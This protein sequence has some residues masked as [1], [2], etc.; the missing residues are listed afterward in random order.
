MSFVSTEFLILAV[1]VLIAYLALPHRL[2]NLMLLCASY[3]FYGWWDWRFLGLL[4]LA[5]G[6]AY[7]SAL[8]IDGTEN[9]R[10]RKAFVALGVTANLGILCVFKY[11]DFFIVSLMDGLAAIGTPAQLPLL[12]LVLPIG[13]SFFTFQTISY[14]VDVY[15]KSIGADRN[16]VDV[17]LYV[18]FFPQLIAGPIERGAHF[19]PQ[20]RLPRT[21]GADNVASG[22]YLALWGFFKKIVIADNLA[23]LVGE[24][25]SR[26]DPSGLAVVLACYAFA[27]QIYCDFSG[28]TDIA[29]GIARTMGFDLLVNFRLPYFATNPSDFWQR[30]HISLSSWLRDYLYI[31]LGG[32]RGGAARTYRNLALTM[33]LGGLWHGAAWNFALWGAYQGALLVTFGLFRSRNVARAVTR[34]TRRGFIFWL[35]VFGFFQLTC[36]GWLLFRAEDASQ[37][38]RLIR[39]ILFNPIGDDVS[40]DFIVK[41]FALVVPLICFQIF[42]YYRRDMEPWRGWR[43]APNVAFC[44]GVFY[45]IIFLGNH[46]Q[47]LF[48]YFQF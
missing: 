2:Q 12:E 41:L 46:E 4:I 11:W 48:I 31:P 16:I 28:Y 38:G 9:R 32:N 37:I 6:A 18:S 21:R 42:Q 44:L 8:L 3:V 24:V 26:P 15:R 40:R 10:R 5:S 39:A 27:F 17:F 23:L 19:L 35:S 14:V 30:W 13:I 22:I 43:V 36:F 7:A 34:Q 29:R 1:M 47:P 45:A 20:I 33:L 25:F